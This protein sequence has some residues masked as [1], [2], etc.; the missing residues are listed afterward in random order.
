MSI[1]LNDKYFPFFSKNSN[2]YFG[3]KFHNLIRNIDFFNVP[4]W[5]TIRSGAE[6]EKQN[7]EDFEDISKILLENLDKIKEKFQGIL[8]N[9]FNNILRKFCEK[10]EEIL[11]ILKKLR[12]LLKK[13]LED[14]RQILRKFC[15]KFG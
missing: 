6:W 10:L 9:M 5:L 7:I 11:T 3:H 15:L 4:K 8:K 2:P 1:V 14:F 13:V 12:E